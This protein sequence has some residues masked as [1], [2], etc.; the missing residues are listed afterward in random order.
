MPLLEIF[1]KKPE[2][3][4]LERQKRIKMLEEW[5]A[6]NPK[7][8]EGA[9]EK[10]QPAGELKTLSKREYE[11]TPFFLKPVEP[12]ALVLIPCF[13]RVR[14][15]CRG[16]LS[17]VERFVPPKPDM[18]ASPLRIKNVI[19]HVWGLW[20]EGD[21]V[22]A[23]EN[24]GEEGKRCVDGD[25]TPIYGSGTLAGKFKTLLRSTEIGETVFDRVDSFRPVKVAER[26]TVSTHWECH[27]GEG[28]IRNLVNIFL[29][30][31]IETYNGIDI[32]ATFDW[33]D[34]TY[35]F[36]KHLGINLILP[37]EGT[38]SYVW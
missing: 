30:G 28:S 38:V 34:A 22:T 19:F 1:K 13:D 2:R 24:T 4:E 16:W 18:D 5:K 6:A 3:T 36:S 27:L 20:L 12:S 8:S 33:Q 9:L 7:A 17:P 10:K 23:L 31:Q 25:Y 35:I 29:T 37:V 14:L 15:R 26:I 32:D 11:T 21:I